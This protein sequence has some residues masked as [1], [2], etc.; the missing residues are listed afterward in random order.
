MLSTQPLLE[1]I[2][3]LWTL[4]TSPTY[5]LPLDIF[6]VLG[7]VLSLAYFLRTYHEAPLFSHPNGLIDHAL[8]RRL[9]PFTR[10]SL[11]PPNASLA[12]LRGLFAAGCVA[13][14]LLSLGIWVKPAAL[15]LYGLAVS[16]YRWNFLVMYVDDA[17]MHL[18]LFWLVVLP[19]GHTL[20]LPEWLAQPTASWAAWQTLT[21][22]G[23]A[24][25]CLLFNLALVYVVAG[26]WKYTSPMWRNG[27]ALYA[28][29]KMAIAHAP[30]FW[31][32][33]H[34]WGLQLSNYFALVL[35]APLALLI[36]LPA[37]HP[38]KW[39]LWV[40]MAGFHLG[41][42]ATMKIPFANLLMLGASS[43]IFSAELMSALGA[44]ALTPQA[45]PFTLADGVALGVVVCLALLFLLDAVWFHTGYSQALWP[46][47][48]RPQRLNPFYVPL[49]LIGLAQSYRLFDWIDERN[50]YAAYEVLE[51]CPHGPPRSVDPEAFFPRA[52][53]HV[54]LQTYLHGNIWVKINPTLLPELRAS[55][56]TAYARRYCQ[57]HPTIT[58]VEVYATVQRIT[59]DNLDLHRGTRLR[60]LRFNNCHGNAV[61]TEM[62]LT[63]PIY[64]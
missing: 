56:L 22:P 24:M 62:C 21:V 46:R 6:R 53:R 34:R 48:M 4:F 55:I 32:P 60:L 59:S 10:L 16:T 54:L 35:E 36:V 50:Y 49:W 27:T 28:S 15:F 52:A 45:L 42:V 33:V 30:A 3:T 7:G 41:I 9:L 29:L 19:V 26:L 58:T 63:P 1:T 12:L 14:V 38:L 43:I 11:F 61:V 57:A 47:F 31:Q 2:T 20:T 13:S 37:H 40:G 23:A 51:L 5:A 25:R 44:P 18:S 39:A 64:S 8:L 17:I